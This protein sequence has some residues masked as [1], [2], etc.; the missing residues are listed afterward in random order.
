MYMHQEEVLLLAISGFW[1]SCQILSRKE[2][3]ITTATEVA[4]AEFDELE[5]N[6][7][8]DS[9]MDEDDADGEA[10]TIAEPN[11]AQDEQTLGLDSIYYRFEDVT[12]AFEAQISAD[13][14]FKLHLRLNPTNFRLHSTAGWSAPLLFD[15]PP[16][17]QVL[18]L[19]H[20]HLEMIVDNGYGGTKG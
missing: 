15:T 14:E 16:S 9:A 10:T 11:P 1:W 5:A 2:S 3:K 12:W 4:T 7:V 13:S 19:I 6:T 17:N 18:Y 20:D 8:P